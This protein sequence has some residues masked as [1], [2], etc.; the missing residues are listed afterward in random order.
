MS[1][2]KISTSEKPFLLKKTFN[3]PNIKFIM[4]KLFQKF[5]S[6]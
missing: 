3:L 6:N 1:Q 5:Q 4:A 2:T